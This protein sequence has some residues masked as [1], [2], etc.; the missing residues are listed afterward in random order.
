MKLMN[1][2]KELE[3]IFTSL[4]IKPTFDLVHI[5]L[6]LFIFEAHPDG[7]GRYRLENEL[8]IGSGTSRSLFRRLKNN[9][10]FIKVSEEIGAT[11]Q[12]KVR[13]GHVLTNNGRIFLN[14]IKKI[15]PL[16][17]EGKLSILKEI[18]INPQ[19]HFRKII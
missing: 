7:I 16:L 11:D 19:I 2:E 9:I 15:I 14:K 12:E 13:K 5:V 10:N 1:L 17:K 6:A 18:I 3:P 8:D 4:T